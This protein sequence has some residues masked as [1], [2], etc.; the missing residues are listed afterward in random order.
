MNL[1]RSHLTST[2]STN[3]EGSRWLKAASPGQARSI[4]TL[5]Q[6]AGRGQRG[7]GWDQ[8]PGKDLA[9]TLAI[10]WPSGH[11]HQ[12]PIAF[13]KAVTAAI[14]DAVAHVIGTDGRSLAIKWPND[15]VVRRENGPWEKCAG[16]LIE[17][18]WKGTRWDGVLVGLGLNVN[19]SRGEELRRCSLA[20]LSG[21][22]FDLA[23]IEQLLVER[24]LG[25]LSGA[26][27]DSKYTKELVGLG[28]DRNY[29]YRGV[30]GM[31]T[32]RGVD[33]EGSLKLDW[34]VDGASAKP[35]TV[36]QSSDLQWDWLWNEK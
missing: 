36:H 35:V 19:A 8:V 24:V 22:T 34:S 13:N 33:K 23:S 26:F 27:D 12:D 9:W 20:D 6:T 31:G 1:T 3:D 17:N 25:Q 14:R 7:S 11:A 10:K 15:L 18:T 16:V 21:R 32:V 4:W 29:T 28:I 30:S 2:T 5:D